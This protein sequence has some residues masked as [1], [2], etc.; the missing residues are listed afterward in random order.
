MKEVISVYGC[1]Q[2]GIFLSAIFTWNKA[3]IISY[4]TQ[5]RIFKDVWHRGCR[6]Q[7]E[8]CNEMIMTKDLSTHTIIQALVKE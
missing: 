2:Y 1:S 6:P 7:Q 3:S 4:V 5:K 8:A